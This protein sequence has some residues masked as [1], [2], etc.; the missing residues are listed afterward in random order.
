MSNYLVIFTHGRSGTTST[1]VEA[2]SADHATD[3]VTDRYFG[4][5]VVV[6]SVEAT[7]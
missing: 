2:E 5:T 6:H 7:D 3:I 4:Q 1:A